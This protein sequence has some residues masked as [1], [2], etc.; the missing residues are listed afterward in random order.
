MLLKLVKVNNN[1]CYGTGGFVER[2][3][4]SIISA[5][6][7]IVTR[8]TFTPGG[9]SMSSSTSDIISGLRCICSALDIIPTIDNIITCFKDV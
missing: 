1:V 6:A 7:Q 4:I 9:A 8:A 5:L 2:K 3:E